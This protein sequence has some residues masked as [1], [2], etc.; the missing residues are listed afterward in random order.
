MIRFFDM[1][2]GIGGF[3]A[4]LE[5]AGGYSCIGHCEIDPFAN[6]SYQAIFD[7]EG[8]VFLVMQ[9][10]LIQRISPTLISFVRDFH[11][12]HFQSPENEAVSKIQ[13]ELCSSKLP[14]FFKKSSLNIFSLKMF[15]ACFRITKGKHSL[16]SSVRWMNWGMVSNGKCLTAQISLSP[17]PEREC[18]LSDIVMEDVPEKYYLSPSATVKLLSKS[19]E[20]VKG[21]ESTT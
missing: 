11:V 10:K 19:L 8:E 3:R 6:R 16:Q 21:K 12:S 14:E 15:P 5:K 9:R 17:N 2:S 20:E 4:G 13:E 1:F 18:F 7:T